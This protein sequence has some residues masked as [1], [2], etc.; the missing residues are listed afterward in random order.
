[1]YSSARRSLI[2][3]KPRQIVFFFW[4]TRTT[5][6]SFFAQ[7]GSCRHRDA[8]VFELIFMF[9]NVRRMFYFESSISGDIFLNT[10]FQFV[11]SQQLVTDSKEREV[12]C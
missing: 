3:C 2:K 4:V 1:M 9:G 11:L 8:Y 10:F 7:T 6:V 12:D 5:I